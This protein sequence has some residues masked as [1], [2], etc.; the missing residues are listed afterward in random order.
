MPQPRLEDR[1]PAR[2]AE[3]LQT[4]YPSRTLSYYVEQEGNLQ[5]ARL[6][7][8]RNR[9]NRHRFTKQLLAQTA[10][11]AGA[12]QMA[13]SREVSRDTPSDFDCG[14]P[15]SQ[16]GAAGAST[17]IN[18]D[19]QDGDTPLPQLGDLEYVIG[20]I[21]STLH[22]EQGHTG[23]SDAQV[24]LV[25]GLIGFVAQCTASAVM[26]ATFAQSIPQT[27][28][29]ML[30]RLKEAKRVL[31]LPAVNTDALYRSVAVCKHCGDLV[32]GPE[33]TIDHAC[34]AANLFAPVHAEMPQ[35]LPHGRGYLPGYAAVLAGAPCPESKSAESTDKPHKSIDV[36]E[37]D[38]RLLFGWLLRIP[39][40]LQQL[41]IK[42]GRVGPS[43]A[44]DGGV[45][46]DVYD[47][48]LYRRTAAEA[49]PADFDPRNP[50]HVKINV[51]LYFDHYTQGKMRTSPSRGIVWIRFLD[52][53]PAVRNS[54]VFRLPMIVTASKVPMV[55]L[56]RRLC[57]Q[58]E[59]LR[60]GARVGQHFVV[61]SLFAIYGDWPA[62]Q[63]VMG[64]PRGTAVLDIC[65]SCCVPVA[66]RPEPANGETGRRQ[67]RRRSPADHIA[68]VAEYLRVS[69]RLSD[70]DAL[71]G[72]P[73]IAPVADILSWGRRYRDLWAGVVRSANVPVR[74]DGNEHRRVL[75]YFRTMSTLRHAADDAAAVAAI[76]GDRAPR[77]SRKPK[78]HWSPLW[79]LL[80]SETAVA[81]LPFDSMH[82]LFEN[83][84]VRLAELIA[85]VAISAD[86]PPRT[87]QCIIVQRYN[88]LADTIPSR[89][90]SLP[91][92]EACSGVCAKYKAHTN[93]L[94]AHAGLVYVFAGLVPEQHIR[95][96]ADLQRI[97]TIVSQHAVAPAESVEITSLCYRFCT[98]FQAQ[99]GL[100]E[101]VPYHH[102]L[103][104]FGENLRDFGTGFA[105]HTFPFESA[106]S[107]AQRQ[108]TNQKQVAITLARKLVAAGDGI[109]VGTMLRRAIDRHPV[110]SLGGIHAGDR[111]RPDVDHE[112]ELYAED[113][114]HVQLQFQRRSLQS[115]GLLLMGRATGARTL[116]ARYDALVLPTASG[117]TIDPSRWHRRRWMAY[118]SSLADLSRCPGGRPSPLQLTTLIGV[119]VDAWAQKDQ[120]VET[121]TINTAAAEA[122]QLGIAVSTMS[123]AC[124]RKDLYCVAFIDFDGHL[125]YGRIKQIWRTER[126]DL[127][128][129]VNGQ[130]LG[131]GHGILQIE[132]TTPSVGSF[133]GVADRIEMVAFDDS[134]SFVPI[135][136]VVDSVML[137]PVTTVEGRHERPTQQLL[138]AR[139]PP[140]WT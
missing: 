129:Q 18:T 138:V 48:A 98:E 45:A 31:G 9:N 84:V 41:R 115:Q 53:P 88:A 75:Q 5:R 49:M 30:A 95:L 4:K 50:L 61:A 43:D 126:C 6:A 51:E 66:D 130:T 94:F 55:A 17:T 28:K 58:I 101:L 15:D 102:F 16:G 80:E 81:R 114:E 108:T 40:F 26:P 100:D 131:L 47:G 137:L 90:G 104:H 105:S 10:E 33:I 63:E 123:R 24:D 13:R 128:L 69:S 127:T 99:F 2:L 82:G 56:L 74:P 116:R 68:A 23:L 12:V 27:R 14:S 20:V 139:L 67:T 120:V 79:R 34:G 78:T 36:A 1:L 111:D 71:S 25:L 52:L 96:A 59:N 22:I 57:Q 89:F 77:S 110:V 140:K 135:V 83:L 87:R 121:A 35:V 76:A 65:R 112:E 117:S 44:L 91:H 21:A 133:H 93:R 122:G 60:H 32:K 7:L 62:T 37:V 3:E 113:E 103:L 8:Q 97:C 132:G 124:H 64:M 134:T 19:D 109:Q 119:L 11:R 46:T 72:P 39:T 85:K 54:A 136:A 125:R 106:N 107:V 118:R 92:I 70:A 86:A 29:Q 73:N 38:L 42:K